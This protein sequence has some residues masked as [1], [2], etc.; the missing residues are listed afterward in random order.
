MLVL[1]SGV[2]FLHWPR[3]RGQCKNKTPDLR[4]A[5]PQAIAITI[6]P[7]SLRWKGHTATTRHPPLLAHAMP[8]ATVLTVLWSARHAKPKIGRHDHD[9]D[10]K[11]NRNATHTTRSSAMTPPIISSYDYCSPSAAV[12]HLPASTPLLHAAP[13]FIHPPLH[14][15]HHPLPARPPPSPPPPPH[16]SLS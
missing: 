9:H 15:H 10:A 16:L 13:L 1:R 8:P 11:P 6:T 4:T 7:Q 5:A 14:L 3:I 12:P 2:L